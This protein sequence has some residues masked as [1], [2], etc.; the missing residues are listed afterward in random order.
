MKTAWFVDDDEEMVRVIAMMLK[1]LGYQVKT[2]TNARAM[3][4]GLLDWGA[5]EILIVDIMMPEV[6]GIDL[7]KF[8]RSRHEWD[9][10]PVLMLSAAVSE[11]QV[12]EATASGAD[13]YVF[14]PVTLDELEIVISMAKEKRDQ[15]FSQKDIL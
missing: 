1:S 11:S 13:G 6:S 9:H 14:K 10:V 8:I 15:K 4:K 5:P 7:L 12:D 3:A 2:F